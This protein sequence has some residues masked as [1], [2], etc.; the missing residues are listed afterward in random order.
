M[1]PVERARRALEKLI[2]SSKVELRFVPEEEQRDRHERY[3]AQ[4]FVQRGNE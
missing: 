1:A 2:G 3:L 4:M